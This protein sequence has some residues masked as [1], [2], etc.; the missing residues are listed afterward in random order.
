MNNHSATA[1]KSM[2][3]LTL[4][5]V[6][7]IVLIAIATA[8]YFMMHDVVPYIHHFQNQLSAV[9]TNNPR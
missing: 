4:V 3:V 8:T 2:D 5:V 6:M 7:A 9:P 1:R